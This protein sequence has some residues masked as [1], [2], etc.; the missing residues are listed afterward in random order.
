MGRNILEF[1]APGNFFVDDTCIDC[2]TCRW[3]APE[4]FRAQKGYS[5]VAHQPKEE[6]EIIA[7]LAAR[8]ACPTNS[9]GTHQKEPASVSVRDSFPREM[10]PEIYYCGYASPDSFG[11]AAWLIR[12]P[13][14][15][16]LIDGCRF[17]QPLVRNLEKM[18]G[19]RHILFTHRDDLGAHEKFARHFG[20]TRWIHRADSATLNF[21]VENL[22][23]ND[24]D[25]V[26]PDYP[27][28]RVIPVPGH[29]RGSVCFLWRGKHLFTGDHL[30]WSRRWGQLRAFR[31]ACWYSWPELKKSMA[32]LANF[33][34]ESI[35]PG[36][37]SPLIT[38]REGMK[39][40]MNR[41]LEWLS[42]TD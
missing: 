23:E 34:F 13:R 12:H 37:G 31:S 16:L 24:A 42:Q 26:F 11:A 29:T 39:K 22:W 1:N 15:N 4:N 35:F 40:E 38:H 25:F 28:L 30:A 6:K 7:S 32:K 10:A 27:E 14:G 33:S 8:F 2:G 9:I 19:L 20:A 3:V 36:H 18:G 21:P 5:Y 17:S 41:C